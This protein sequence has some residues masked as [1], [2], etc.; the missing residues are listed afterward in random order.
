MF[1]FLLAIVY[2]IGVL[3]WAF[4]VGLLV[5]VVVTI[6]VLWFIGRLLFGGLR[7]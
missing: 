5:M 7:A 1:L 6:K 4:F 3:A 2:V